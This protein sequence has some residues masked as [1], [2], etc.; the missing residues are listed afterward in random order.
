MSTRTV[1]DVSELPHHE[2]D[3]Y[4]P[5]WWGNN[6]LLAIETS[7]FAILIATYFYLRQNFSLWPPPLASLT[8]SLRP[9][10]DLGYGTAT[11]ILLVVSCIPLILADLA[12]RRGNRPVAQ[13]TLV[14]GVACGLA[15]MVLRAYEF[16]AMHFRWDSNAYGSIVWFML[17]MHAMHLLVLTSETV[18]LTIWVFTREFDMKHRVDI[19][20]VA[21]YWYWVVAIW[22]FIYTIVYFTPRL[23]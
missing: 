6:M 22:L 21:V 23:E 15:A 16:S 13:V 20:T 14:I 7:M 10:P 18:L 11:T 1:I 12:A 19:V 9:L 17:G 2:F 8:A 4:D 5:V 3:T